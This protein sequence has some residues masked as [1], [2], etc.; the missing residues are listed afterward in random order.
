[1][2]RHGK[3]ELD[4]GLKDEGKI[5]QNSNNIFV[6]S[7]NVR[8]IFEIGMLKQLINVLKKHRVDII[9]IQETKHKDS[10]VFDKEG[11]TFF[12]SSGSDRRLG[13]GFAVSERM[14]HA[15][16]KFTPVSDRMCT[17]RLRGRYQK[18]NIINIHAPT[19]EKQIDHKEEFY[20]ALNREYKKVLKYDLKMIIGDCNAKIGKEVMFQPTI[21][22]YSKH[23]E[24]NENGRFLIDFA[25]ENNMKI[26]STKYQHKEIHK[27]TWRSPDGENINQ[28]DHVLIEKRSETCVK[29]VR[30]YRGPDIDTDHFMVGAKLKQIIPIMRPIND[31]I[32]NNLTRIKFQEKSIQEEF[33]KTIN[34]L[35]KT[36]KKPENMEEKAN[37]LA[38]VLRKATPRQVMVRR[39][40]NKEWY[41]LECQE[42]ISKREKARKIMI[43]TKTMESKHKFELQRKACKGL[44]REKKRKHMVKYLETIEEKYRNREIRNFYQGVKK[45]KRGYQSKTILCQDKQGNL[46]GN[47]EKAIERWAEYFE[48]LLNKSVD[49]RENPEIFDSDIIEPNVEKPTFEDIRN[50]IKSLKNNRSAGEDAVQA[51]MLKYGGEIVETMVYELIEEIWEKEEMPRSW[52]D[53]IICPIHKKG[54]QT[55]CNNY[56]GIALLNVTYKVL[57]TCIKNRLNQYADKILGEYQSGFRRGRS[58][59]DQI[60]VLR[61]IQSISHE[62]K[63]PTHLLFVDFKQAYDS[64]DR[65]QLYIALKE[66]GIP[67]KLIKLIQMTLKETT[68]KVKMNGKVSRK[69]KIKSG[70]RQGDPLS[71]ALF[72]FVLEMALRIS[73]IGGN[74]IIF[75]SRQQCLA[76]ADDITILTRTRYELQ[77]TTK[78]ILNAAQRMGL[79]VNVAKTKYMQWNDKP[80]KQGG[81]LQVQ[82]DE[83]IMVKF[84]E[85]ETFTYLGTLVTREVGSNEEI[86]ARIVAGN[87]S[88]FALKSILTGN[89]FSRSVKLKSI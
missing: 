25:T 27:G 43:Q 54:D 60:Y 31:K 46:I 58:V 85:V 39:Y 50:I 30:T 38:K 37:I 11:Y 14:R 36:E 26:V 15:V 71:A 40:K 16:I 57:A 24:T 4:Y 76:F 66:L 48:E 45:V 1:M 51:E 44:L 89:M 23:A 55:N 32:R 12:M 70:L 73:T 9:A 63:L 19:E 28:I 87:K 81:F 42:E 88:A 49:E 83:N 65:T 33:A 62:H 82:L 64:V 53:A 72:N 34:V 22:R 84:E 67:D 79:E 7:W 13:T 61:E 35:L 8:G 47:Q 5:D 41:D 17:L 74:N 10:G 29:D 77:E 52:R 20:E 3:N 68:N 6:T 80:F 56:R 78:K 21:G 59:T 18:I 2:A 75:R 86:K 69:F